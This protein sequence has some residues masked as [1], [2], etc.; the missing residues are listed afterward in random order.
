MTI[1]IP[2]DFEI[3]REA[4]AIWVVVVVMT[5]L[6]LVAGFSPLVLTLFLV[7]LLASEAFRRLLKD[8]GIP[9]AIDWELFAIFR[10]IFTYFKREK[11]D[12]YNGKEP[13]LFIHGYLH[14]SSGWLA[15]RKRLKK[16][17]VNHPFYTIDLGSPFQSI[18]AY[19]EKVRKKIEEIKRDT[20][21]KSVILIGHSMGG[22][23]S[24]FVEN[25]SVS[26]VITLGSPLEGTKLAFIGVGACIKEMKQNHPL[27]EKLKEKIV[28]SEG[29]YTFFGSSGDFIIL[30]RDSA[31]PFG[32]GIK[33]SSLG[34]LFLLYS[35]KVVG[36]VAKLIK[37]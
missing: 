8:P 34:H 21:S 31:N 22:V 11:D 1:I 16:L 25:E 15:F 18:E 3:E 12:P 35:Q 17:G 4:N 20:G 2:K 37:D 27:I 10:A 24:A 28:Q 30:P 7:F 6:G 33:F 23:V 5:L 19:G 13:I 26:H 9:G 32:K 36:E 14:N 29:K